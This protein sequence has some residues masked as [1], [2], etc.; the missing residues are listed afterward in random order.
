M[1][2]SVKLMSF[3]PWQGDRLRRREPHEHPECGHRVWAHAAAA[4]DGGVELGGPHGLPKPD[5]GAY[6]VGV[7]EH[8]RQVNPA[9]EDQS[10]FLFVLF[11]F[12]FFFLSPS[13]HPGTA[14]P[15]KHRVPPPRSSRAAAAA[16]LPNVGRLA[17]FRPK[18]SDREPNL[19]KQTFFESLCTFLF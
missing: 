12:V 16:S 7:R 11:C 9:A 17:T 2:L 15:T 3:P 6:T 5:S 13:F 8:F 4:G 10:L 1:S 18:R 19:A 14:P